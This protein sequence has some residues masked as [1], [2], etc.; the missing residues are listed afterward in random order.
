VTLGGIEMKS[1]MYEW[2]PL[3]FKFLYGKGNL[4]KILEGFL[5]FPMI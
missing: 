5:R 2:N 4:E 3:K 1:E